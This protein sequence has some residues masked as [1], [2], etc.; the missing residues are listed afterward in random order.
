MEIKCICHAG[1]IASCLCIDCGFLCEKHKEDEFTKGHLVLN[2]N[3]AH[4]DLYNAF[5]N[6]KQA[7]MAL[8]YITVLKTKIDEFADVKISSLDKNKSCFISA[9]KSMR[10]AK[11]GFNFDDICEHISKS[12]N[13]ISE[14]V[15]PQ[16]RNDI[17]NQLI[18]LLSS[19]KVE[20]KVSYS[21][22]LFSNQSILKGKA[23]LPKQTTKKAQ[24]TMLTRN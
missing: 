9:I 15:Y 12:Y 16:L 1:Q 13:S 18:G 10:K 21:T 3:K 22:D 20:C 5:A 6:L 17:A 14:Q 19:V 11:L 4:I 2:I 23:N 8:R 7:D 24:S